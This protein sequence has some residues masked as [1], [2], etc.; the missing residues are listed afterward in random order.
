MQKNLRILATLPLLLLLF[1]LSSSTA[2]ADPPSAS[3]VVDPPAPD[4]ICNVTA[5]VSNIF[6]KGGIYYNADVVGLGVAWVS[7]PVTADSTD[8]AKNVTKTFK[9]LGSGDI[10]KTGS[11]SKFNV[12]LACRNN[13]SGKEYIGLF[14]GG[15]MIGYWGLNWSKIR[16]LYPTV[17]T[18][19][20]LK[21]MTLSDPSLNCV[22]GFNGSRDT[23][24]CPT[25]NYCAR[26]DIK[27]NAPDVEVPL[28][29]QKVVGW[30]DQAYTIRQSA[31]F[32]LWEFLLN[33]ISHVDKC[34]F[35]FASTYNIQIAQVLTSKD[36]KTV[37][38]QAALGYWPEGTV[39]YNFPAPSR[40]QA[41]SFST[42]APQPSSVKLPKCADIKA[43]RPYQ[44]GL[45]LPPG[46]GVQQVVSL[47]GDGTKSACEMAK[48]LD[49]VMRNAINGDSYPVCVLSDP[50]NPVLYS[51]IDKPCS[52]S[53]G[54][55]L[56]SDY[57]PYY[58]L[59]NLTASGLTK[60]EVEPLAQNEVDDLGGNHACSPAG[61][62]CPPDEGVDRSASIAP[63]TYNGDSN[64]MDTTYNSDGKVYASQSIP[65]VDQG[66][67]A[68]L[69]GSNVLALLNSDKNAGK[70]AQ[71]GAYT[72]QT[73]TGNVLEGAISYASVLNTE[74]PC[75]GV[76]KDANGS[77]G[78]IKLQGWQA[79]DKSLE[80]ECQQA[81]PP[82]WCTAGYQ[83]RSESKSDFFSKAPKYPDL[84]RG[85]TAMVQE[86][87]KVAATS[88]P[89][90][91]P[92]I[93]DPCV[94][95]M[96]NAAD[97]IASQ[98]SAN[99]LDYTL[100]VDSSGAVKGV[101]D[102]DNYR[103]TNSTRNCATSEEA[104]KKIMQATSLP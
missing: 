86:G 55:I 96:K 67:I 48:R 85:A 56:S 61:S 76:E 11:D 51:Q 71:A 59:N 90:G 104:A 58:L 20:D 82:E 17:T 87:A 75:A 47:P 7:S 35:S 62:E 12:K 77:C 21:T 43:L 30:N 40:A 79:F 32:D 31:N 2:F 16:Q 73:F 52:D 46:G 69:V 60:G 42:T 66:Q 27:D 3:C 10:V 24:T 13:A 1:Y 26:A 49:N 54:G 19:L 33:C 65:G 95:S 80:D 98:P 50:Q 45:N 34:I 29:P 84:N 63:V 44:S 78:G 101:N 81:E 97:G 8:P 94:S 83:A 103:I 68:W 89:T 53:T 18:T 99:P 64:S 14:C 22:K 37:V 4:E 41:Q 36:A 39:T 28:D 100:L 6:D 74:K 91:N 70:L 25:N 15:R 38:N 72:T 5:T 88:I 92:E 93:G 102:N 9:N 23:C 57:F